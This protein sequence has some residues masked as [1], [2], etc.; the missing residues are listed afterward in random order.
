MFAAG[1]VLPT[2]KKLG[3]S[4]SVL[5]N[6]LNNPSPGYN[7]NSFQFVAGLAYAIH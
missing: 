3:A 6:Y 5:D 4:F 7:K 1:V 2:W